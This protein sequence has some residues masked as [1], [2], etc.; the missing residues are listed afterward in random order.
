MPGIEEGKMSEAVET[1][2]AT[3]LGLPATLNE[4]VLTGRLKSSM[5]TGCIQITGAWQGAVKV[6]CSGGLARRVAAIMFGADDCEVT[7]DQINDALGEL[8]NII[9]GNIKA[10]LPEPSQLSMPAVTEGTDYLFSVP[11]S[12]PMAEMSFTCDGNPFQITI[13]EI[14]R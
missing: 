9:G 5:L 8:T 11:G 7:A 12:R 2:W 13:L 4:A 6:E 3:L 10:L 14:D 1:V